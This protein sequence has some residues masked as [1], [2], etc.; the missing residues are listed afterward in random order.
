MVCYFPLSNILHGSKLIYFSVNNL[1]V[2][3]GSTCSS[4]L[5]DLELFFMTAL[6]NACKLR[7][8]TD[9]SEG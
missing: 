9:V 8:M 1:P 2:L 7:G 3:S 4:K 6:H 5:F